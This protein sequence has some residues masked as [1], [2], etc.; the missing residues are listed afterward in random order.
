MWF[1]NEEECLRLLILL[2]T[3]TKNYYYTIKRKELITC[4]FTYI[5]HINNTQKEKK[6]N[7]IQNLKIKC[8]KED[9]SLYS[10]LYTEQSNS[11]ILFLY[12][13]CIL[14]YIPMCI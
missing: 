10:Y 11:K 3:S 9:S 1:Y 14:I 2:P 12:N 4:T 8:L 13:L 6:T 5:T 7:Y